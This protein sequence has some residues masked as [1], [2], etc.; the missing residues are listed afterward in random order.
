MPHTVIFPTESNLP[1]RS[2]CVFCFMFS[3]TFKAI[4]MFVK[5]LLFQSNLYIVLARGKGLKNSIYRDLFKTKN[6]KQKKPD[7]NL[8]FTCLTVCGQ[9]FSLTDFPKCLKNTIFPKFL[10]NALPTHT[11]ARAIRSFRNMKQSLA[12]LDIFRFPKPKILGDFHNI[13]RLLDRWGK[14]T[15]PIYFKVNKELPFVLEAGL[16]I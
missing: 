2:R 12:K 3:L 11:E 15:V 14:F 1:V 16:T 4:V 8:R 7:P 5:F 6:P 13:G 9:A 10:A